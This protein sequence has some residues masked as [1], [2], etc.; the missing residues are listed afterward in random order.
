MFDELINEAA[1]RFNLSAA[2]IST[3]IRGLLSSM[4]NERT[5]GI[6]GF[7]DL[8][9]NAGLGD[10]ITSWFGGREGRPVTASHIE[11]AL[12]ASAIDQLAAPS[13]LSRAA[14][15][16]VLAFLVPRLLGILTPNGALPSTGALTSKVASFMERAPERPAERAVPLS[17]PVMERESGL[18][19]LPWAAAAL[20]AIVGLLWL[21]TPTGTLNPQL[22]LSN[23]DGK[24]TY[25]GVVRDE[26]TR[27]T[28][29]RA[30]NTA[31][32]EGNVSGDIRVDPNVKRA[33]WLPRLGDL[34]A[35]V[36]RPGV[37]VALD[38]D[39]INVG[40]W[41]SAADRAAITDRLHGIFG[42]ETAVGTLGNPSVDAVRTAN[43][44]AVSALEA[45][46][47]SGVSPDS[48][49]HAMN[50]GIVNFASGSAEIGTESAEVLRKSADAIKRMPPGSKIRIDGHTDN[51]G[52]AA[53]NVALSQRRADAVKAALVSDGV[54]AVVLTTKGYGDTRPRASNDTEYGRFQNRRIEYSIAR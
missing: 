33:P 52:D 24:V 39:S 54:S 47:T 22:A 51:T 20:L 19:W 48:V 31:Y 18:R 13:G 4:T 1:S 37:D 45:I 23:R 16:G 43:D 40:G 15:S 12:G 29:V 44:N 42:T 3:L 38:G 11:S 10:V 8:F 6:D 36:A 46:G 27:S 14:T 21:R 2:T 5:G 34:F 35:T 7:F 28:I 17:G 41:V 49:V 50:L 26:A 9:R 32:G 25:T 30:L 53:S